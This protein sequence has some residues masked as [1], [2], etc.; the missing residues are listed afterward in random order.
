M[1]QL[2]A[3]RTKPPAA[4]RGGPAASPRSLTLLILLA[5]L[6]LVLL[7][8]RNPAPETRLDPESCG[9]C[10][11]RSVTQSR[12]AGHVLRRGSRSKFDAYDDDAADRGAA[13]A[14][15]AAAAGQVGLDKAK[16]AAAVAAGDA[17]SDAKQRAKLTGH[18]VLD[19]ED[20]G[21]DDEEEEDDDDDPLP[22]AALSTDRILRPLAREPG[23]L[24]PLATKQSPRT[25]ALTRKL[26][27]LALVVTKSVRKAVAPLITKFRAEGLDVVLFHTDAPGDDPTPAW[28]DAVG[29]VYHECTAIRAA[30]QGKYWFAKRFLTPDVVQLYDYLFLWDAHVALPHAEWSPSQFTAL[31]K[32]FHVHIAQPALLRSDSDQVTLGHVHTGSPIGRGASGPRCPHDGVSFA[33]A[34]D[35]WYPVCATLGYCRT[36]VVD[37]MAVHYRAPKLDSDAVAS[38]DKE[39]AALASRLRGMCALAGATDPWRSRPRA[40]KRLCA[41][42]ATHPVDAADVDA[43]ARALGGMTLATA[44]SGECPGWHSVANVP[45]WG[46]GNAPESEVAKKPAPAPAPAKEKDPVAASPD[47]VVVP[48]GKGDLPN[49]V[50]LSEDGALRAKHPVP[51]PKAHVDESAA[52]E[53]ASVDE[54]AAAPMD[55]AA[56]DLSAL[57]A[58]IVA[59]SSKH[60][61]A[62]DPARTCWKTQK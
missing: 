62:A 39:R 60:A 3:W 18:A 32:R 45:W 7:A 59:A 16:A 28:V 37:A 57:A 55:Q 11:Q 34:N 21:G 25:P 41:Y 54:T 61:A 1:D 52:E 36:A 44:D 10:P 6:V 48:K 30:G 5:L 31:L 29:P 19:E 40:K 24:T 14:A 13:V 46:V 2:P 12:I 38:A 47:Q 23:N 4:A 43:R 33:G 20:A 27:L 26:G 50:E 58:A 15:A 53:V 8:L 35:A 42:L 17:A 22:S 49:P 51:K 9:R 56:A